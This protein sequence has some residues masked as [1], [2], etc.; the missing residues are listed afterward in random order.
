MEKFESLNDTKFTKMNDG[1]MMNVNGGDN[2]WHTWI[3]GKTKET[4]STGQ[5]YHDKINKDGD[6]EIDFNNPVK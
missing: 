5:R 3:T 1:E 2:I 6:Q 4:T